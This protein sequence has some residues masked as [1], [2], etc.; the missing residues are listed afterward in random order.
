MDLRSCKEGVS[1][2]LIWEVEV[3]MRRSPER[4]R[5]IAVTVD[6]YRPC[7]INHP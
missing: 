6:L 2:I 7:Q 1:N 5:D 3:P 4:V